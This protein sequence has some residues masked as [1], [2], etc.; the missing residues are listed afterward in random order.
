MLQTFYNHKVC[1]SVAEEETA[2]CNI[3]NGQ[4]FSDDIYK[5]L[6]TAYDIGNNLYQAFVAERLRPDSKIGIFSP[7]K[8][9]MLK[10]C[11]SANKEINIKYKDKIATL[12][13]ENIFIARIAMIRGSREVDMKSLIGSYELSPFIHS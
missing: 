12:K 6:I 5:N 3:I 10:L 11:K 1:L 9:A 8:K 2:F 4:L 7:L 13:E